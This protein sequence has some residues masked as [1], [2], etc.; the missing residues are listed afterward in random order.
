MSQTEVRWWFV[1][2]LC[3]LALCAFLV[4]CQ[5]VHDDGMA[6]YSQGLRCV[7]EGTCG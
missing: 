3:T 6:D 1:V 4:G 7:M 2:A 5:T